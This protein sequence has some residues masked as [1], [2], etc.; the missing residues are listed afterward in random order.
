[1]ALRP[2]IEK[3]ELGVQCVLGP[4]TIP[5]S[6]LTSALTNAQHDPLRL[7]LK[8]GGSCPNEQ[9]SPNQTNDS[10]S[11]REEARLS[12]NL[13]TSP[14]QPPYPHTPKKVRQVGI[15]GKSLLRIRMHAC[16]FFFFVKFSSLLEER[17]T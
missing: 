13:A 17:G 4:S 2:R 11:C 5:E 15:T 6:W 16:T 10:L 1:L 8:R 3:S 12:L 14:P 9:A 7:G